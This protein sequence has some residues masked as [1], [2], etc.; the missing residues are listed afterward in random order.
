MSNSFKLN[1]YLL[2]LLYPTLSK[3]SRML[4]QCSTIDLSDKNLNHLIDLVYKTVEDDTVW[5]EFLHRT[6]ASVGGDFIHLVASDKNLGTF[7]YSNG[8]FGHGGEFPPMAEMDLLQ[9]YLFIDPRL[10]HIL[11][12]PLLEWSRDHEYFS[13]EFM[14][15][16]ALYQDFLLPHGLRYLT[17]TIVVD[18]EKVNVMFGI[19]TS[20]E[21]GPLSAE[22]MEF[23]DK[24]KTHISRACNLRMQNFVYSTQALV[25]HTLVNKLRQPVIL[26]TSK[27]DVVHAN[28]AANNLLSKTKIISIQDGQLKLPQQ[29]HQAFLDECATLELEARA[30]VAMQK[31]TTFRSL[32]ITDSKKRETL[33]AF[34]N[35]LIPQRIMGTFGLR[36]LVMLF[37]YH[38]ESAPSIDPAILSA[39]FNLTPAE[40]RIAILL[41]DGLSQKEIA[42]ALSIRPDTVRKQLQVIYQKTATKQQSELIRLML[43]LPSN[44][45]QQ[46]N[47]GRLT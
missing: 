32:Q 22:S 38:P 28:E 16:N 11:G 20:Q 9:K 6:C 12:K 35:M 4:Q 3:G 14:D 47:L 46:P 45:V 39:A 23:L 5:R 8:C 29:Y 43:H 15:K 31:D 40:C 17:S 26:I 1:N 30:D 18:N 33:Y 44:F 13:E 21:N 42:S 36:P 10:P 24:L 7:S 37:F 25:G 27:G 2:D 19:L 41:G 34:Y